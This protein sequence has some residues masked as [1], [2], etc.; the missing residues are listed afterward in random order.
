MCDSEPGV[1]DGFFV[2]RAAKPGFAWEKADLTCV[3]SDAE[4]LAAFDA[5][6]Q[7]YLSRFTIRN[8]E[9]IRGL[10]PGRTVFRVREFGD[11]RIVGFKTVSAAMPADVEIN[12][13]RTGF[14]YELDKGFVGETDVI[15][16]HTDVP[17]RVYAVFSEAQGKPDPRRL[18]KGG[19]YRISVYGTDGREIEHRAKIFTAGREKDPFADFFIP[20]DEPKGATYRLRD[21]ATGL[22]SQI[23]L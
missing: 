16:V 22:E 20:Q 23:E 15:K 10:P 21:I 2:R 13:G 3:K 9:S 11:M 12:L 8:P 19:V 18:R 14:V 5:R 6:I 1:L 4:G 17:F 7:S